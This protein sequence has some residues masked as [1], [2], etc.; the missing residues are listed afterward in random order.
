MSICNRS[1]MIVTTLAA[2]AVIALWSRVLWLE[3]FLREWST[4]RQPH[5]LMLGSIIG[6]VVGIAVGCGAFYG[7]IRGRCTLSRFIVAICAAAAVSSVLGAIA[8]FVL[9]GPIWPSEQV[10][11]IDPDHL[12]AYGFAAGMMGAVITTGMLAAATSTRQT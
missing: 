5:C 9:I 3:L 7:L 6:A 1:T 12:V 11:G 4:P 10:Y 2:V 8:S